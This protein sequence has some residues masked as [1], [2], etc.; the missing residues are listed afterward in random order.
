MLGRLDLLL[1]PCQ[2][3][4][5]HRP[6]HGVQGPGQLF[7]PIQ[8]RVRRR[9][10]VGQQL[11]L[12][13]GETVHDPQ[14]GLAVAASL[15]DRLGVAAEFV[16][17]GARQLDGATPHGRELRLDRVGCRRPGGDGTPRVAGVPQAHVARDEPPARP[18]GDGCAAGGGARTPRDGEGLLERRGL[19]MVALRASSARRSASAVGQRSS[20]SF[21]SDR[22]TQAPRSS[23]TSGRR[24]V[25]SGGRSVMCFIRIPGTVGA[26]KGSSPASIWYATTPKL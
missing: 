9:D 15:L 17:G 3:T 21:S 10:Y 4:P 5:V 16:G 8:Q 1:E 25:I 26:W 18:R 24:S 11:P 12:R 23:G 13:F 20:G 6:T 7:R 22:I 19:Y 2:G 14:N